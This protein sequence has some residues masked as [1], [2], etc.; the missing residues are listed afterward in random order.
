MAADEPADGFAEADA[1]AEG[2]LDA[3]EYLAAVVTAFAGRNAFASSG[4]SAFRPLS[5]SMKRPTRGAARA[6][7]R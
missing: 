5:A 4:R 6:S 3:D 1:N 7:I 2:S